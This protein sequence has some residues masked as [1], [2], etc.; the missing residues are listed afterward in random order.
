MSVNRCLLL[1]LL[2]CCLQPAFAQEKNTTAKQ[3]DSARVY[4]KIQEYSKKRKF[5]KFLHGLIFEPIKSRHDTKKVTRKKVPKINYSQYEG[6]IIR[7]INVETLD[8]FGYSEK[9]PTAVP[10]NYLS[11]AGNRIH[12]RS[13]A[14]TIKN[15]ILLRR[16]KPL[17]SLLLKESE[18]LV[19]SQRFVRG[20]VIT[21]V[22]IP[23]N[24][25]SVDINIREL[26]A[27]SLIP[28]FAG[29]SSHGNFELTERNFLG[30]GH[31]FENV[32][33]RDFKSGEDA[34]STRY[35][36]P[37]IMNTYIKTSVA[38]QINLDRDY[39]KSINVERPF[40]SPFTRWAAGVYLDQQFRSDTLPDAENVYERQ[41]FKYNSQDFWAG[42]AYQI[43]TENS[44][45][46]R[47]TNLIT[48]ARFLNVDYAE[49]PTA[50]YDSINFY[51]DE[52]FFM[53]SVGISSRQFVE[54]KFVFNYNIIEDIPVGRAFVL[55]AGHQ[56]KNGLKRFY[57]G[58]RVTLGKYYKWGYLSSNFE[59]GTFFRNAVS[60]QS[61]VT[62]E[63]MY[64]TNLIEVGSR[65]KLR[66]FVKARMVLGSN[67]QPSRG[68][69]LNLNEGNGLEGFSAPELFG[70]KKF[71]LGF[72][73]Q[74]YS[75][76]NFGGFRMNPYLSYMAAVLG[77]AES[78][79]SKSKLFSQIGVGFIISNDYLVFSQFQLS[80]AYYPNI[81]GEGTNIFKTNA[82]STEDF[83][84]QNFDVGK[85]RTV[86]Y[87]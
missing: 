18:R 12:L 66:Q 38:Y 14:L 20:V 10:K 56:L 30:L 50:V 32:Y 49:S 64:F 13:K 59:Y 17:D 36:I 16:N 23:G 11:K 85:P 71:M 19:R 87:Q 29:S 86:D 53:G 28:D 22:L 72:Q 5:T 15:L 25:D 80:I 68:D 63:S 45:S 31:Q 24:R 60:E 1:L 6:K 83:G 9:D 8:P 65:W 82:F 47:T 79:F 43:F 52:K 74:G 35:T 46:E 42:H 67:R 33:E 7:K 4:K 69:M 26:D 81:P 54:D 27:W 3:K 39:R 84:F 40:F 51:S 70:T 48:S 44:E 77:N 41:N 34:Y 62:A 61:A 21:P 73:T 76:W 78:G 57:G 2:I 37:N 58:A 75:P 55:T